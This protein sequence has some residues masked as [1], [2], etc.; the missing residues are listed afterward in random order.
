[1][2][3]REWVQIGLD[4]MEARRLGM[5]SSV[6]VPKDA[7]AQFAES[8]PTFEEF[9]AWT[10]EFIAEMPE[11]SLARTL[12]T[13]AQKGPLWIAARAHLV[14]GEWEDALELLRQILTLDSE[15][16]AAQFNLGAVYRNLGDPI[17]SLDFYGRCAEAFADVGLYYTNR[18]RTAEALGDIAQATADYRKALE[19]LPGDGFV[20]EQLTRLGV[21][22]ELATDPN[23]P[24]ETIFVSREDYQAAIEKYWA[25]VPQTPEFFTE[26]ARILLEEGR[27]ELAAQAATRA[28]RLDS[29]HAL[30]WLYQGF[31][32]WRLLRHDEA[33][34]ALEEYLAQEPDSAVGTLNL[35]K[36]VWEQRGHAAAVPYLE[37]AI[38]RDPNNLPAL[39]MLA[40][41]EPGEESEIAIERLL[42]VSHQFPDAWAPYRVLGD[43][44]WQTEAAEAAFAAYDAALAR[45]ADDDTIAGYLAVLGESDRVE[46]LCHIADAV[47]ALERRSLSVRW[48]ALQGYLDAGRTT[49]ATRVLHTLI[50]DPELSPENRMYC[51]EL[52]STLTSE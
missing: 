31:A 24:E 51:R 22:I 42:A 40:A 44:H 27:A 32:Y 33:I 19:L 13:F 1:M 47:P 10:R 52:L 29:K 25:S 21:L 30:A 4:A 3:A 8:P 35:A 39:Q 20:L 46:E 45:G 43:L 11:H 34:L 49:D 6:P 7:L 41:T 37:R 12:A 5:P 23:N 28:L 17:R 15:D 50:D 2:T 36:I 14:E 18:A 9:V 16:A 38:A 26:Q 48:N